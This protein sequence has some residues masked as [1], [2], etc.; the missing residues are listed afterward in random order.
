MVIFIYKKHTV[1]FFLFAFNTIK[2]K[3][4]LHHTIPILPYRRFLQLFS[5]ANQ[6]TEKFG[7]LKEL[8]RRSPFLSALKK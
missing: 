4:K 3:K 5:C 1:L 8:D 7:G 2:K 6:S